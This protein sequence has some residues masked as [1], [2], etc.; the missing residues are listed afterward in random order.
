MCVDRGEVSI[1]HQNIDTFWLFFPIV[2]HHNFEV[3][4]LDLQLGF[5]PH[6]Q[7]AFAGSR[8]GLVRDALWKGY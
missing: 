2:A 5:K 6:F 3:D 4:I 8:R 7:G 1:N